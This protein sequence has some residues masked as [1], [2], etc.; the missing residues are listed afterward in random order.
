MRKQIITTICALAGAALTLAP[1]QT[2]LQADALTQPRLYDL[3]EVLTPVWE[4]DICYQESVLPVADGGKDV[5]IPLL[6]PA[7]EILK[8]QNAG[9]TVTYRA[10]SDYDILDGKLVVFGRGRIPIMS[11]TEFSPSAGQFPNLEDG[12]YLCFQEGSYFH[13]RQLV[14]TYKHEGKYDGYVPESKAELL[15]NL[16]QK[17]QKGESLDMFVLG[18]SISVGANSSG[19]SEIF[20]SPYMPI[21]PQLFADGLKQKYGLKTVNVYNH[22]VGGKNSAWGVNEIE[23]ALS[24]HENVDLAVLA[25]GMN[26]GN[27]SPDAF[28]SNVSK[29]INAVNTKFPDAEILLVAT[30]LPNPKSS[31][32]QL[33]GLFHISMVEDL[34]T[35]GVAVADVT[36]VHESLLARKRYSDMTG[37]NI[38]H[39]NDYL[40]R[41]YAQT[42][43]TTV[44]KEEKL[45]NDT[46]TETNSGST[47]PQKQG[48]NS[49]ASGT[50]CAP[51]TLALWLAISNNIRR[52]K[53]E[54]N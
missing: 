15:P 45:P 6:Y 33:Q 47:T 51:L 48:C 20:T 26:D 11:Q 7:T 23:N 27:L 19:F 29:M 37:N 31:Y 40:A 16:Q 39:P 1:A 9:L 44:G 8:V 2:A 18:D 43:L 36:A 35:N 54:E 17:L 12:G 49:V 5:M 21:Y 10:G 46:A 52:K 50:L 14:V 38:N 30:M 28:N 4:R 41:V 24:T 3:E 53:S 32:A 25:F 34:Q 13:D 22:S 42:L